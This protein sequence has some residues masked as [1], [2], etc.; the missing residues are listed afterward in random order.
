[1]MKEEKR[2]G[3]INFNITCRLLSFALTDRLAHQ[4]RTVDYPN[5][6][7]SWMLRPEAS[8]NQL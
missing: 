4:K 5:A 7:G 8:R 6:T 3:R 2:E 1:M